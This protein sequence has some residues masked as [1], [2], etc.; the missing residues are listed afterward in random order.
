MEDQVRQFELAYI[1]QPTDSR[2]AWMLAQD[3]LDHL[4]ASTAQRK[5]FVNKAA[6]FEVGEKTGCLLA[7]IAQSQ[8]ACPAIGAI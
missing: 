7:N 2:E 6:F 8:H 3:S 4:Q 5:R 1:V